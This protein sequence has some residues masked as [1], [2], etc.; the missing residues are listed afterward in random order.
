MQEWLAY[1]RA[2]PI[3]TSG[4]EAELLSKTTFEAKPTTAAVF[5]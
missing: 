4:G 5:A 3:L 1:G 2:M